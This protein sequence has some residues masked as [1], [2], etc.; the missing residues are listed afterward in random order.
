MKKIERSDLGKLIRLRAKVARDEV[1]QRAARLR[2][3]FEEQLAT[4][5]P[6]HHEA[7]VDITKRVDAHIAVADAEVAERCRELHI[8]ERFRPSIGWH[9]RGR[10]ESAVRERREELRRVAQTRIAACAKAAKVEIDRQSV[11]LQTRLTADGLESAAAKQFLDS[12]PTIEELMP[13][14]ILKELE[15]AANDQYR[16]L[17]Y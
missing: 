1:D 14:L 17:H 6:D 5:Y 11:N 8:P 4:I 9:W 15:D 10:G 2:A 16:L 3:D 13:P 7:W 12:M